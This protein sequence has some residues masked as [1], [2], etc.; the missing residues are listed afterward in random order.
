MIEIIDNFFTFE[1]CIKFY[2]YCLSCSYNYGESDNPRFP[3][4]GMISELSFDNDWYNVFNQTIQEKFNIFQTPYRCYI[5]LFFP[6]ENP[7][8]HTDG[9]DGDITFL[10]YPNK[11]ANWEINDGGETKFL[12]NDEIRGIL[13]IPNRAIIF[14]GNIVHSASSFRNNPR[15]TLAFKYRH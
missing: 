2:N 9:D 5:N 15:F 10:Y 3:K 1:K 11:F 14:S 6:Q 8:Y 4:S 13:P 12:I 7:Y